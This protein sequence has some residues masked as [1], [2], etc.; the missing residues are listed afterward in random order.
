M[1]AYCTAQATKYSCNDYEDWCCIFDGDGFVSNSTTKSIMGKPT[2]APFENIMLPIPEHCHEYLRHIYGDYM[3][4]PT[5]EQIK[6]KEH[7]PYI[8]DLEHSYNEYKE[9]HQNDVDIK[10]I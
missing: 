9:L 2:Y 1:L 6:A 5:P 10:E 7:T 4:I 8:L 3:Q